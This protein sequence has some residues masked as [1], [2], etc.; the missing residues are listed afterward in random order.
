MCGKP[1][2]LHNSYL[3][4]ICADLGLSMLYLT[5]LRIQIISGFC[6]YLLS[7]LTIKGGESCSL[8]SKECCTKLENAG[9]KPDRFCFHT[10]HGLHG[11]N[12]EY[13]KHYIG[14]DIPDRNF[15][16]TISDDLTKKDVVRH[17]S[18]MSEKPDGL[19]FTMQILDYHFSNSNYWNVKD[20]MGMLEKLAHDAHMHEIYSQLKP[21]YRKIEFNPPDAATCKCATDETNN[22]IIDALKMLQFRMNAFNS[23]K[24]SPVGASNT[25]YER[26]F[27]DGQR[28][29]LMEK[30]RHHWFT[31]F[32]CGEAK[33]HSKISSR[34]LRL[35]P[36]YEF[37]YYYRP[38]ASTKTKDP[39]SSGRE[40]FHHRQQRDTGHERSYPNI[41]PESPVKP[42]SFPRIQSPYTWNM[43]KALLKSN[44]PTKDEINQFAMYLYCK[45]K[46]YAK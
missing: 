11:L 24:I 42:E 1:E 10:A 36:R 6:T 41:A 7:V 38:Y 29:K 13:V 43:W 14:V 45:L 44:I 30:E 40:V 23:L 2:P 39:F 25:S 33:D 32:T 27:S 21:L 26:S 35:L 3:Q 15:I 46:P 37:Y 17:L 4:F 31:P 5:I 12:I 22:G 8:E 34:A 16:P 19:S 28:T 20:G 9:I 18:R